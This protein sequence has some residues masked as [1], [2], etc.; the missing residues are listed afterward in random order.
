MWQ[1]PPIRTGLTKT[2]QHPSPDDGPDVVTQRHADARHRHDR[3]A[4][5]VD[6]FAPVE[7]GER[8]PEE[9]GDPDDDEVDADR[10][11]DDGGGGVQ[12]TR[13]L[14]YGREEHRGCNGWVRS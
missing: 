5:E 3:H 13:H 10:V 2:L 7:P 1:N 9:R 4:G 8:G 12:V 6:G 14:G 11:V